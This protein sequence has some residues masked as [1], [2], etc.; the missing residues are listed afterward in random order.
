MEHDAAITIITD[1]SFREHDTGG[2]DHPEAPERLQVIRDRL[3][4]SLLA[5]SLGFQAPGPAERSELLEQS[6][7]ERQPELH[8]Q[9][10]RDGHERAGSGRGGWMT[11]Q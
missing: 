8:E 2:N 7:A 3:E 11:G 6:S 1:P 4:A 9:H 5:S 10:G